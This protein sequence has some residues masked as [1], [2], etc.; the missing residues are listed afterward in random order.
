LKIRRQILL[1]VLLQG[2]GGAA[3]LLAAL[4]IG[5]NLGPG[6]Q[7]Q[8]NLLKS[9]IEF[10]AALA[11][12]GMPQALYVHA[13]SGRLDLQTARRIGARVAL[14]GLPVGAVMALVTWGAATAWLVL[15]LAVAVALACLQSQWRA[16]SLLGPTSWRFNLVTATPQLLLLPLAA[17]IVL[18]AGT[19]ADGLVGAFAG[20][21]LLACLHAAWELRRLVTAP[22]AAPAP[23]AASQAAGM[24]ALARHGLATWVTASL[25]TFCILW[26]QRSADA[27]GG[28]SALGLISLGLLLVQLPLTPLGYAVPLLLRWRMT[29]DAPALRMARYAGH[30][31]L[32][33]G[34]LAAGVL[35][36]GLWWPDLW[37]GPAYTGLYAVVACLML[38]GAA[39]AA[40]RLLA[41]DAQ[42]E[43]RPL[44][45]AQAELVRTLVVVAGVLL[46]ASDVSGRPALL[47]AVVWTVAAFL[48]LAVLLLRLPRRD[49]VTS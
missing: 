28:A 45:T 22:A 30:A 48:A 27:I 37:M 20:I 29:A 38:G 13:Q 2:G 3:T 44:H 14:L 15:A 41:V 8:F 42:A 36:L 39:E 33:M 25:A 32:P 43:G 21:W 19:T 10:G 16:L 11:A 4:W 40:M 18:Q 5:K 46:V 17:W 1:A 23:A 47:L 6:Q 34:L 7:G 12:L 24:G 49:R 9:T 31:A 26:I 35:V